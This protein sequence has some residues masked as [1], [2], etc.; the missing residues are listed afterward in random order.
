MTS[1]LHLEFKAWARTCAP[2]PLSEKTNTGAEILGLENLGLE[3][4]EL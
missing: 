2:T 3:H 4:L 1:L